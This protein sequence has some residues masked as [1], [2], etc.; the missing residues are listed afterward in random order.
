MDE[1][2]DI[3]SGILAIILIGLFVFLIAVLLCND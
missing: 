1:A 2:H 3:L